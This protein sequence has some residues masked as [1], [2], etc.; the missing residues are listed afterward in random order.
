MKYWLW[1]W[2]CQVLVLTTVLVETMRSRGLCW[3]SSTSWTALT[4]AATSKCWWPPTD[5]TPWTLPSW[6][7]DV[8]TGRSSSA[9]LIWRWIIAAHL[10]AHPH[11]QHTIWACGC[12]SRLCRFTPVAFVF[13]GRTHIFKIHAR[14]M[15]VERDI[16]FELL[17]RLCPNS[18]GKMNTAAFSSRSVFVPHSHFSSPPPLAPQ[19]CTVCSF[20]CFLLNVEKRLTQ[21]SVTAVQR[22]L[23][24]CCHLSKTY[25][26][27]KWCRHIATWVAKVAHSIFPLLLKDAFSAEF[28][29]CVS[30][31]ALRSAV[32]AQRQ[33]CSPSEPAGRLPQRKT[34][35]KPS[36]R[37]SSPT[38]S[39]APRP[40]TWPT[41]EKRECVAFYG[42][43]EAENWV[44][45][46]VLLLSL[47]QLKIKFI[48]E[49]SLT[50][51]IV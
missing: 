7:L 10:K 33:A 8:W 48:P 9:C 30:Y 51:Y 6:D 34:S 35:W 36:T 46:I 18:T 41:T 26:Q 13:Q 23:S 43:R 42:L 14:S 19:L 32:C 2:T 45:K 12:S 29:L 24:F 37:S 3:S 44:K 31:Q 50:A 40:D 27:I 15:S 11:E 4:H 22:F 25:L 38:P 16:R 39:S 47:V 1:F 17:A 20:S 49:S 5:Q 21:L 28:D